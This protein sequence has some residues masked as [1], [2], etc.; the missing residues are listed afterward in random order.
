[1]STP[2]P[3]LSG[4]AS[5]FPIGEFMPCD[6]HPQRS[7]NISLLPQEALLCKDKP[8]RNPRKAIHEYVALHVWQ[9]VLAHHG[10]NAEHVMV[11]PKPVGIDS[12]YRVYMSFVPGVT[13][14]RA[15]NGVFGVPTF[16]RPENREM[17]SS[18]VEHMGR[19]MRIKDVEGLLH[20]DFALRH[21]IFDVKETPVLAT[22]DVENSTVDFDRLNDEH[23][24]TKQEMRRVFRTSGTPQERDQKFDQ[25]FE[26]GYYAPIDTTSVIRDI[27]RRVEVAL[28]SIASG[29]SF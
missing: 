1:M 14:N 16:T 12:Q 19:L 7:S 3:L 20:A 29:V 9:A 22:I 27:A 28:G 2:T 10:Q 26:K 25:A 11:S 13:G 4:T 17:R 15:L 21:V 23:A 24:K 18:F 6:P 5:D 8:R